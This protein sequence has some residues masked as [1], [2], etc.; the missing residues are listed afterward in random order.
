MLWRLVLTALGDETLDEDRRLA[1]LARGAAELAARRTCGGEGPTV[2]DVVR[3][4][5]E[6]FAVV[7]DAAQA[8]TALLGRVR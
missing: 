6:E 1:I 2:D 4:A 3:L 7:I 8:R 5:F